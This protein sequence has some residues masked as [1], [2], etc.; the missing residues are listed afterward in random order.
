MQSLEISELHWSARQAMTVNFR[1]F[2]LKDVVGKTSDIN[3]MPSLVCKG[4]EELR[5]NDACGQLLK[6]IQAF[7]LRSTN[8]R[9]LIK[10]QFSHAPSVEV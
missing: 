5:L 7:A 6:G 10:K 2:A 3:A 1:S 4:I 9:N 8:I